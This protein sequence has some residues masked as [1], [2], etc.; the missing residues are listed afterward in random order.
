MQAASKAV[1]G[2]AGGD[3][4]A[5]AL[6][7]AA[8]W[9]PAV[10]FAAV[11]D[12]SGDLTS[13]GEPASSAHPVSSAEVGGISGQKQ[14]D[15][16]K[17]GATARRFMSLVQRQLTEEAENMFHGN[18]THSPPAQAASKQPHHEQHAKP[19]FP[20][21]ELAQ[22]PSSTSVALATKQPPLISHRRGF[23]EWLRLTLSFALVIKTLCVASN[24]CFQASPLPTIRRF[25]VFGDT[26]DIDAAPY[27]SIG[28]GCI[29]WCFYGL[30]ANVVTQKSGFL[31]LFY[32]NCIGAFLG[33]AY[34]VIFWQNCRSQS[35]R[36]RCALYLKVLGTIALT[37]VVLV[38][39]LPPM[40]A[41]WLSGLIS[42]AWSTLS[43]FSMLTT[44]GT[45][46]RTQSSK[47]LPMDLLCAGQINVSLW[48]ICGVMLQDQWII[49]PQL[50]SFCILGFGLSLKIYFPDKV[51]DGEDALIAPKLKEPS[52]ACSADFC[53]LEK[54]N[55][56][57]DCGAE[58][59]SSQS[60]LSE[61]W[62]QLLSYCRERAGLGATSA[63]TP[64]TVSSYGTMQRMFKFS[65]AGT[66]EAPEMS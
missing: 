30:F 4:G 65:E 21:H 25:A 14:R 26:G 50:L 39:L 31:V 2:N 17:V 47:T 22:H 55:L 37:Q 11:Y 54:S 44:V 12:L 7:T 27:V 60:S 16:S 9:S 10:Q 33:S 3:G 5:A 61:R 64:T 15:I 62:S 24:I 42:S 52:S 18:A 8:W 29:Q 19:A 45:V 58:P 32:S 51:V 13:L 35:L 36:D 1:S 49:C 66:G 40:R 48:L 34:V 56:G 46:F 63:T 23:Y 20:T 43:S 38:S 59:S 57:S 53:K 41:L 6:D 28:F